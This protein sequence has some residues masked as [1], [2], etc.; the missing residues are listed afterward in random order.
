MTPKT[1]EH[2]QEVMQELEHEAGELELFIDNTEQIY[3]NQTVYLQ[4]LLLRHWK[5]GEYDSSKALVIFKR[6]AK[7]GAELYKLEFSD[8]DYKFSIGIRSMCAESMLES[9]EIDMK[10]GY[11]AHLLDEL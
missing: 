11:F 4:K 5:K 7:S 3:T 1:L 9:F 2:S 10:G 6:L 8:T